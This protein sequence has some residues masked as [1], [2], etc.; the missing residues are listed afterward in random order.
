MVTTIIKN[1]NKKNSRWEWGNLSSTVASFYNLN[2]HFS[3]TI[4][5]DIDKQKIMTYIKEGRKC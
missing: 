1:S 5:R 4:M 3:E 2:V